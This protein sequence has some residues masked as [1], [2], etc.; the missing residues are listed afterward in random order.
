MVVCLRCSAGVR[1]EGWRSTG[2]LALVRRAGVSV[3]VPSV[4]VARGSLVLGSGGGA[5]AVA[6]VREAGVSVARAGVGPEGWR[7]TVGP[8]N[9]GATGCLRRN[10]GVAR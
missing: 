3:G 1:R 4:A 9:R 5:V 7:S 8:A 10:S 6:V 2:G